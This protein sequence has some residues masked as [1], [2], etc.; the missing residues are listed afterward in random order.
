MIWNYTQP[1][2]IRFGAGRV[3]EIGDAARE[4]GLYRGLLV[5]GGHS[6]RSGLAQRVVDS[7][8]GAIDAVFSDFSPNPDV[9]EVDACAELIRERDLGFIV[10][11]GGGSALDL[12][13]AASVIGVGSRET[14]G[15]IRDYHGTGKPLPLGHLPLIAVP[16][17]AGTGSEVTC[18]SV[19][20]DR[21]AGVKA[22]IVSNGFY[23]ELAIVDPE[24]TYTVPPYVTACTGMDVL[25]QA[26]E[27]YWSVG[28]QPICD[29]LAVHAARLVFD[30]LPTAVERPDDREARERMCEASVIAGLAFTLP[31]TTSSHAC[32]FPLTNRY[33]I[34]HGEACALTL[35]YFTRVNAADPE[36]RADA[37]GRALGYRD[38]DG[39]ADAIADLRRALHLRESLADLD[40]D[41]PAIEALVRDSHHPNLLNNPVVITD[42]ILLDLFHRLASSSSSYAGD[43]NISN[44]R[45][46]EPGA[47]EREERQ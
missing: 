39:L 6:V 46:G 44:Q 28:H 36:G 42:D 17:T 5:A 20:T 19:L 22:P 12:A 26:I 43:P 40:L 13:K 47:N 31:K 1:V 30:F 15:S 23:P 45:L 3:S 11:L 18:V 34:A 24:L 41:E 14:V 27:G 37:L 33:G 38:A 21:A 32:S 29:A 4:R 8:R 7:G 16:T 25:S 10:A 35:D 9:T 2:D